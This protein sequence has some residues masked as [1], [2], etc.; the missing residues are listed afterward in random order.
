MFSVL[1]SG[2][3]L[4]L[5]G[6]RNALMYSS[7]TF[8]ILYKLIHFVLSLNFAIHK[9]G[10]APNILC[11]RVSILFHILLQDFQNYSRLTLKTII[12]RR[13]SQFQDGV[14][15]NILAT[16]SSEILLLNWVEKKPLWKPKKRLFNLWF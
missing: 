14:Q 16:L 8:S 5:I 12:M 3:K 10:N 7:Y 1:I 6:L 15:L 2:V 9:M 4:L 13:P 11:P